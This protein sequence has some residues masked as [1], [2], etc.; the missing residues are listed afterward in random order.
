MLKKKEKK[1]SYFWLA[2]K[3]GKEIGNAASQNYCNE[4]DFRSVIA[5][6]MCKVLSLM[7]RE[8]SG[9]CRGISFYSGKWKLWFSYSSLVIFAFC[10]VLLVRRGLLP[11]TSAEPSVKIPTWPASTALMKILLLPVS[12]MD[13]LLRPG[14]DSA[15]AAFSM[16]NK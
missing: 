10:C 6:F 2:V 1:E 7:A 14:L 16:V 13:Q 3:F 9:K 11:E 12:L 8:K 4:I 5:G 15:I